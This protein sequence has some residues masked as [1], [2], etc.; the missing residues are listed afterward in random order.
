VE[1]RLGG[2]WRELRHEELVSECHGAHEGKEP[3]ARTRNRREMIVK[4]VLEKE[5]VEDMTRGLVMGYVQVAC[6]FVTK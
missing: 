6:D 1:H 4:C 5:V 2:A 3:S